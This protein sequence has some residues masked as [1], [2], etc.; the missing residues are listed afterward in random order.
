[1]IPW[2]Y[3]NRECYGADEPLAAE[4]C[5]CRRLMPGVWIG[6]LAKSESI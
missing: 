1:M 6:L 5:H 2:P 4:E 3:G